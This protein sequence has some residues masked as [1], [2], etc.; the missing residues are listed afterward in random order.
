MTDKEM[1]RQI[2]EE[3]VRLR[4]RAEAIEILLAGY[5]MVDRDGQDIL[6]RRELAELREYNN[7]YKALVHEREQQLKELLDGEEFESSPFQAVWKT[8]CQYRTR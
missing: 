6:W 8:Y 3:M 7:E 2:A 1:A 5:R 4:K